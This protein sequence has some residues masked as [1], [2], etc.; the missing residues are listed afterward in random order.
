M[1]KKK[2]KI[3]TSRHA[4]GLDI[5]KARLN[6][7][8]KKKRKNNNNMSVSTDLYSIHTLTSVSDTGRPSV[9]YFCQWIAWGSEVVSGAIALHNDTMTQ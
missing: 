6:N 7:N 2:D 4:G 9:M 8:D 3:T 5:S 1:T